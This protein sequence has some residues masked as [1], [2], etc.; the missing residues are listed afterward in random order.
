MK[1]SSKGSSLLSHFRDVLILPFT[2]TAIVPY[3]IY[4]PGQKL[5]PRNTIIIIAGVLI[6]TTGLAL[7][8][9]TVFLFKL[10]GKGT[11]APW[12][13]KQKLVIAGPYRFCRNPMITGVLF[14]LIGESLI[15]H[16][17]S[18]LIWAGIFFVINTIYFILKEE[19]DLQKKFGEEYQEYKKHVP[20]WIPNLKPYFSSDRSP[21][22]VL[23][24]K[25]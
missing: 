14:I 18:I 12:S 16:S 8:F 25:R 20:R 4:D 17:T 6:I 9:M 23:R 2:A 10:I 7:F 22:V 3:L 1:P 15:L 11:L 13:P 24:P 5:I 21:P 19:P